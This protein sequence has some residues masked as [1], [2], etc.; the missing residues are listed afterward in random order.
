MSNWKR[1]LAVVGLL[2]PITVAV[3]FSLSVEKSEACCVFGQPPTIA[4]VTADPN[5][6]WPPNH[7][8]VDLVLT[9]TGSPGSA[10]ATWIVSNVQTL[11][12]GKGEGDPSND[13]DWASS[14]VPVAF[15]GQPIIFQLRAER[16]GPGDGRV[17]RV[18]VT[19]TNSV[20]YATAVVNVM[21]P[22]DM[23]DKK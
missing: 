6:L 2:L 10:A 11:D 18:Y 1:V 16:G 7:K 15:P 9:G 22:H 14:G 20:G 21:V 23:R 17:Y 12:I 13:P 4:S 3:I 8:M 5:E 19:A